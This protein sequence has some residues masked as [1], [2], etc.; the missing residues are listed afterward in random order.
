MPFN[1]LPIELR[2]QVWEMTLQD[3]DYTPGVY[4]F[5]HAY[6]V[7]PLGILSANP[8]SDR[9][10]TIAAW[11]RHIPNT[12]NPKVP[13]GMPVALHVCAESRA[14]AKRILQ[15]AE[16]GLYRGPVYRTVAVPARDYKPELDCMF[17]SPYDNIRFATMAVKGDL[18]E[19]LGYGQRGGGGSPNGRSGCV[20]VSSDQSWDWCVSRPGPSSHCRSWLT[21]SSLLGRSEFGMVDILDVLRIDTRAL[22]HVPRRVWDKSLTRAIVTG[23]FEVGDME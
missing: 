3:L 11:S 12:R 21:T 18:S 8:Y 1:R 2:D 10:G 19:Y 23:R 22:R 17:V 4:L 14:V 16:V 13:Q 9:A 20:V 5:D 6:H 15:F 7:S